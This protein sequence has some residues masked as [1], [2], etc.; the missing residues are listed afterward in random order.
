MF[1]FQKIN[2]HRVRFS[3]CYSKADDS[4]LM[5][6]CHEESEKI[7]SPAQLLQQRKIDLVCLFVCVLQKYMNAP[8]DL[9]FTVISARVVPPCTDCTLSISQ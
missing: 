1:P 4:S 6:L 8:F 9:Q 2:L 3:L 7:S 5:Q